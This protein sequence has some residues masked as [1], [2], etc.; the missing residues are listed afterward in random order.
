MKFC[1][2]DFFEEGTVEIGGTDLI[3]IDDDKAVFTNEEWDFSREV[4]VKWPAGT[5]TLAN[6][7]TTKGAK[8]KQPK[9]HE[10][11]SL[12]VARVVYFAGKFIMFIL[13]FFFTNYYV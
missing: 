10:K 5:T 12:Y 3:Q 4:M 9:K 1:L 11:T 7:G 13:S 6:K 8:A 2:L